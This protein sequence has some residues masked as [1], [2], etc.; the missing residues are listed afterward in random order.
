MISCLCSESIDRSPRETVCYPT[1]SMFPEVELKRTTKTATKTAPNKRFN[2]QNNSS[3][4]AL[5]KPLYI[6]LLSSAKQ[7]EMT[8]FLCSLRNANDDG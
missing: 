3:A 5:Y 2:D 1:I 7:R 8:K 4:R 6:S